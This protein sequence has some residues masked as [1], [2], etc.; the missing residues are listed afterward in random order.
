MTTIVT[1]AGKGSPLTNTEMDANLNNLNND[2]QEVATAVQKTASTKSAIL[3][4]G[5]TSERDAVPVDGYLRYNTELDQFEG[6]V[7]ATWTKILSDLDVGTSANQVVRLTAASKLP[8]VDGSLLTGVVPTIADNSL[9]PAKLTQPL[10]LGTAQATTS[11]TSKDF[12]GIP[13]W[14]KRITVNLLDVT[15]SG[16]SDILLQLGTSGGVDTSGYKGASWM[17]YGTNTFGSSST[18]G[19]PVKLSDN[20]RAIDGA[21]ITFSKISGDSWIASGSMSNIGLPGSGSCAGRKTLSGVLDRIRLTTLNGTDT[22]VTG[23]VNIMY[24]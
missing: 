21:S 2:K 1:R 16:T 9:T 11:G 20:T 13:S 12:T 22:F 3:P 10:T 18:S 8:A 23:S 14:V 17:A 15:L 5:I 6:S 7:S 19:I 4:S 24:E